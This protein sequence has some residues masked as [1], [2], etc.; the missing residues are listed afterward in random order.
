MLKQH[1]NQYIKS[2]YKFKQKGGLSIT[3]LPHTIYTWIAN[4][5][6]TFYKRVLSDFWKDP[7]ILADLDVLAKDMLIIFPSNSNV[8]TLSVFLKIAH[9]KH[10]KI[11]LIDLWTLST[12]VA[13][14]ETPFKIELYLKSF[15]LILDLLI[16][17]VNKHSE[18]KE[19]LKKEELKS[20]TETLEKKIEIKYRKNIL[21][22]FIIL[23]II[24]LGSSFKKIKNNDFSHSNILKT[25]FPSISNIINLWTGNDNYIEN[26]LKTLVMFL[27]EPDM[28]TGALKISISDH[29]NWSR[30][31]QAVSLSRNQ[32]ESESLECSEIS[33]QCYPEY[34]YHSYG[35]VDAFSVHSKSKPLEQKRVKYFLHFLKDLRSWNSSLTINMLPMMMIT[36]N[37]LHNK[38]DYLEDQ[39]HTKKN[40]TIKKSKSLKNSKLFK[41]S[42]SAKKSKK[43]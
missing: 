2:R 29:A 25:V 41:K 22:I 13:P 24:K 14:S 28:L 21:T 3:H 27:I 18:S 38:V 39:L 31:M 36:I 8:S 43:L 23:Y 30:T 33:S 4:K 26:G 42:K 37:Q 17:I 6:L 34:I 15:L 19:V 16:E 10:F 1:N 7:V 9:S 12:N 32:I 35:F 11:G 40:I 5:F 20:T